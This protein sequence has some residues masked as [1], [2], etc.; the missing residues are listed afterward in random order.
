VTP[1]A[2]DCSKPA[3]L[4]SKLDLFRAL[5]KNVFNNKAVHLEKIN[6]IDSNPKTWNRHLIVQP[7]SY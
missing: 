1:E 5:R 6:L 7:L 3:P 2:E 4:S